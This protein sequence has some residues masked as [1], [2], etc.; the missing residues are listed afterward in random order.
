MLFCCDLHCFVAKSFLLGFTQFCVDKNWTQ[1]CMWRKWQISGMPIAKE[2]PQRSQRGNCL[3]LPKQSSLEVAQNVLEMTKVLWFTSGWVLPQWPERSHLERESGP[4]QCIVVR[5][6]DPL[7]SQ[8]G[9]LTRSIAV[10]TDTNCCCFL[11]L[12]YLC[13]DH[14]RNQVKDICTL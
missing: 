8:L 4:L 3:A 12:C 10:S 14:Y 2:Q 9:N 7:S 1:N 13:G 5:F 6:P 11:S